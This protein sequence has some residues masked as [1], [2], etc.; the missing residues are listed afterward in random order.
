MPG[1]ISCN[2]VRCSEYKFSETGLFLVD[3]VALSRYICCAL[4]FNLTPS[5][6][7]FAATA[8]EWTEGYIEGSTN[9]VVANLPRPLGLPEMLTLAH[10]IVV[11]ACNVRWVCLKWTALDQDSYIPE[12][13]G[14]KMKYEPQ[15]MITMPH[16]ETIGSL[17]LVTLDS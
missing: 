15:T 17:C 7:Q 12:G 3:G 5:R 1:A 4:D 8:E 11:A 9:K 6:V 16:T 13:P 10:M 14:K 2:T